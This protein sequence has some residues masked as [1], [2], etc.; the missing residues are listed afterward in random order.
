VTL[1]TAGGASPFT[2]RVAGTRPAWLSFDEATG[3]LAGVPKLEP[4]KPLVLRRHTKHGVR[5]IVRH[6]PA[7][8]VTYTLYVTASDALGQRATQKLKLTVRP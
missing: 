8:P 7:K 1:K 3:R 6:R 5:T 4:R 2:F